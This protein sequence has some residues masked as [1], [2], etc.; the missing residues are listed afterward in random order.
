MKVPKKQKKI[1][2]VSFRDFINIFYSFKSFKASFPTIEDGVKG[3]RFIFAAKK[4]SDLNSKWIK[5]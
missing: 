4:S 2:S 5:I 1:I 3:I